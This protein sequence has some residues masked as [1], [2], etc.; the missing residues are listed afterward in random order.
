MPPA[1]L[2]NSLVH[3]RDQVN[4]AA[5]G[6][7][8]S[9]DGW[10]GDTSHL[11][12][13]SDH[14]PDE[15]GLVYALDITNDPKHGVVARDIA[16]KIRLS[17]DPRVQYVISNG[18]IANLDIQNGAWRPYNGA[19]PHDHHCHISVRHPLKLADNVADWQLPVS[20]K[21]APVGPGPMAAAH[22][23]VMVK[24]PPKPTKAIQA[25][26]AAGGAVAAGTVAYQ[27]T[28]SGFELWQIV[29][30]SAALVAITL[31][32]IQVVRSHND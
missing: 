30:M 7:D 11:A 20:L 26:V 19:S 10:I 13:K 18:E 23:T 27:A 25:G 5:P 3:L 15:N 8:K 17:K 22:P 6:R 9:S 21:T 24:M 14:N 2:V 29:L 28:Q 12:H 31:T 1:R 4:R 16:D 32:V